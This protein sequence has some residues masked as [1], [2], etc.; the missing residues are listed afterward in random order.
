M[1]LQRGPVRQQMN[2]LHFDCGHLRM[3]KK[4]SNSQVS[5]LGT[6]HRSRA[7]DLVMRLMAI[8]GAS[9][10]EGAVAEFI[11]QTLIDAG[12]PSSSVQF[13]TANKRTPLRGQVGNLIVKLPGGKRGKPR[14]MLSAHMDTVPICV[15]CQ[16]ERVGG[17]IRS[18]NDQTGLGADDRAGVAAALTAAIETLEAG[19]EYPP[20]TLCFFV[21]EEIGLQG[22]R[23]MTVN[24]L[25]SPSMAL[26]FDGGTA[27]KM[28]IGATGGERMKVR[29]T[30]LPAHAGMAPEQ[31][32]SAITAA[33]LAIAS[34][35]KDRWLGLV[36][37]QGKQGTS[38][39]GVIQGGSATNVV[40]QHLEISMEARSHDSEFRTAIADAMQ[41]AF[42]KAAAQVTSRS[43]V[44][45]QAN[46]ER[47][48]DYESFRLEPGSE[49]VA[50]TERAIEAAGAKPQHTISNG[51]VDA[52]WLVR[53]GI[54][55][56]TVGCGQRDVHTTSE[57][58]DIAR[59]SV[60]VRH[61]TKVDS[62][63]SRMMNFA[64]VFMSHGAR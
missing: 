3:P 31:G 49:A 45:V 5:Q 35:H 1:V 6:T 59:I 41:H 4:N 14:I 50:L 18:K 36:K 21:Q 56:V 57:T 61:W 20:L 60:G 38:N 63:C 19:T 47:R 17:I 52:N 30:G 55:T 16:P 44:A 11:V 37:K 62:T 22:S 54:P 25:G 34:L 28:T 58:L 51:G 40:A 23:H 43:G 32:A 39:L 12:V 64:F 33:G 26:N 48:V 9:G 29:L 46:V 13:D 53:H 24:K 10:N 8:P 42:E 2:A 27:S 7:I 15:G